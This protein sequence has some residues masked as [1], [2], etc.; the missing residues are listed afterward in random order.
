M[1][2]NDAFQPELRAQFE[3]SC[4]H[5]KDDVYRLWTPIDKADLVA[6]DR[7]F[8]L[9]RDVYFYR[10]ARYEPTMVAAV[11]WLKERLTVWPDL[12]VILG[13]LRRD[14]QTV[15][16]GETMAYLHAIQIE[17]DVSSRKLLWES[18]VHEFKHV[19]QHV[20]NEIH[21][22]DGLHVYFKNKIYFAH[23]KNLPSEIGEFRAYHGRPWEREARQY[24]KEY[25]PELLAYLR[26]A[27]LP[28]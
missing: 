3:A 16:L 11:N 14:E 27:G 2:D 10:F 12:M 8:Q 1:F 7:L 26:D 19:S 4:Q 18:L 17:L 25:T 24:A 23:D 22:I 9:E 28:T 5:V 15:T 21:I 6:K 20:N 13:P